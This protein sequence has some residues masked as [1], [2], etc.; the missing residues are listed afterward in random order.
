MSEIKT[1]TLVLP[2]KLNHT[3]L[4]QVNGDLGR[5]QPKQQKILYLRGAENGIF[6]QGMDLSSDA[7]DHDIETAPSL[8]G[9]FLY[10]LR[11]LPVF[12]VSIIEGETLGGG[13][14]I[15]AAS[16]FVIATDQSSLALPE[17]IFGL[18]PAFCIPFLKQRMSEQKIKAWAMSAEKISAHQAYR[19]GLV[20]LCIRPDELDSSVASIN[21]KYS[22]C[23]VE[24][25]ELIKNKISLND[26]LLA[27]TLEEAAIITSTSI[28]ST[29]VQSRIKLWESG[30]APWMN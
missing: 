24:S 4:L 11:S 10:S 29:S 28:K 5:I 3:T 2:P 16:D 18:A 19:F 25:L 12:V 13:V 1:T 8:F 27:K 17:A 26:P 6:C 20:D 15:A 22:R 9:K 23:T 21:K 7:S 14:A 30:A